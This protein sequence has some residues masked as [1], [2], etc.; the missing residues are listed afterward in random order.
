[1]TSEESRP[2]IGALGDRAIAA[3]AIPGI[4]STGDHARIAQHVHVWPESALRLDHE[5][6]HGVD[7][8]PWSE[9]RPFVGREGALAQLAEPP[10]PGAE[11]PTVQTI[12]GLAGVGK[13][14]LA[15]HYARH[16]RDRY[17][18]IWW[19]TADSPDHLTSGL[20]DLAF[21]L[22]PAFGTAV[23][24]EDAAKWAVNWLTGHGGWLL[25]LDNVE[26]LAH[27]RPVLRQSMSG[28]VLVTTRRDLGVDPPGA[29]L[30]LD[31]LDEADA[32]AVLTGITG[33][34]ESASERAAASALA[35]EL[36]HLPLAL[37]QIGAY[38]VQTHGTLPDCLELL[39]RDP[40]RL[41][42]DV[43]EGGDPE[44]TVAR[45][46]RH[47]L[48]AI[49]ERDPG[50][51]ELLR[52]LAHFAADDIPRDVL[53]H[54]P[55][56]TPDD[57]DRA[58]ALL[59]SYSLITLTPDA[60]AIHRLLQSVVR[61]TLS[62]EPKEIVA[63]M[64]PTSGG[65]P[66]RRLPW[67]RKHA[68]TVTLRIDPGL[69]SSGIML[70]SALPKSDP[71]DPRAWPRWRVLLPHAEAVLSR[72]AEDH[73]LMLGEL[74]KST[75][76]Y[77]L[78]QGLDARALPHA[79]RYLGAEEKRLGPTE[80]SR[81]LVLG[82]NQLTVIHRNLGNYPQACELARRALELCERAGGELE[83]DATVA[84]N[85]LATVYRNLDRFDEALPLAQRSV[86]ICERTMG[87]HPAT[88]KSLSNLAL[89]LSGLG[90]HEDALELGE[91][92]LRLSQETLPPDHPTVLTNLN[93]LSITHSA[94]GQHEDAA[95]V[96]REVVEISERVL[97]EDHAELSV[98]LSNLSSVHARAGRHEEA[99]SLARR[100]ADLSHRSLGPVHPT[101]LANVRNL[102]HLLCEHGRLDEG[103][104]LA[105]GGLRVS[106]EAFGTE[107]PM[108]GRFL[109][110]LAS[111]QEKLE[112][113]L[114]TR[115]EDFTNSKG[116]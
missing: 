116:F 56:T 84:L 28:H 12:C 34:G 30:R 95:R 51:V 44:R 9:P 67:R 19:I 47:T 52:A 98:R 88:S 31:V 106:S 38:I 80:P 46:W 41:H 33:Y 77:L 86:E 97:G 90:R 10:P 59:N 15:R 82:L 32:L 45:I 108:T 94:L 17:A 70:L 20:A 48:R 36:G 40:A 61:G 115:T 2:G 18:L 101:T 105:A 4:A 107:H 62:A 110:L 22:N 21:R 39:R 25:V 27:V 49:G 87:R 72:S 58:L 74:S 103:L 35:A 104:I 92:A 93:N 43:P 100:A 89:T 69:L 60:V 50:A 64:E 14:T 102:A 68:E 6:P 26:D 76:G 54:H 7:N 55:F 111:H 112:E 23:T 66:R 91:R 5:T 71:G 113:L 16:H 11:G 63:F 1:M 83:L 109:R 53:R 65:R 3:Q 79:E 75:C 29:R 96:L 13:S 42:A 8:V 81:S 57:V 73:Q 99:L 85:N 114:R 24:S 78:S 37:Q